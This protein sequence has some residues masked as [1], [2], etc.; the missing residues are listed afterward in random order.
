MSFQPELTALSGSQ[1][2][3]IADLRACAEC[4]KDR[5][6]ATAMHVVGRVV[7][8]IANHTGPCCCK[9][10]VWTGITVGNNLAKEYL[11]VS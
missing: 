7:D 5:G 9:S 4:P 10:Y 2:P 3:L 6:S 1:F 11:N 8:A